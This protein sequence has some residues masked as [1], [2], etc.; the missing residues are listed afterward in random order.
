M[1][2]EHFSEIVEQA[3]IHSFQDVRNAIGK[4]FFYRDTTE[5]YLA[6]KQ[7]NWQIKNLYNP[8]I[9]EYLVS[10]DIEDLQQKVTGLNKPSIWR[11]NGQDNKIELIL[12]NSFRTALELRI[13]EES[14]EINVVVV[15]EFPLREYIA[16]RTPETNDGVLVNIQRFRTSEWSRVL[17]A[18]RGLVHE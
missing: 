5:E 1:A 6:V 8:I 17:N 3:Q 4:T 11:I 7:E 10:R 16:L 18:I 2:A 13:Y 15:A 14:Q 9:M 12:H